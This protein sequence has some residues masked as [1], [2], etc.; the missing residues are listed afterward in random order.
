MTYVEA[1]TYIASL[2]PRGWRLGLD[3][4]AEFV[5][6]AGLVSAVD[7]SERKFIHV[8]GTNGKGSTTAYLQSILVASG[9][10]TGAFFSPYVLDPGERIQVGRSMLEETLFASLTVELKEIAESMEGTEFAGVTEFE[11]KTALGFLAWRRND[12]EWVALETGLGGR[13]DATNVVTPA[14]TVIV[15]I[16]LDHQSVLGNSIEEIA[17]E[18]AGIIKEGK[19]LILGSVPPEAA[20]VIL[21]VARKHNS[22]VWRFGEEIVWDEQRRSVRILDHQFDDLQPGVAGVWQGHNLALAIAALVAAEAPVTDLD[23]R[24]GA[25]AAHAPGRFQ[26]VMA[27]DRAFILD[28]AHNADSALALSKTLANSYGPDARFTFITNILQGHDIAS[29]Y[30]PLRH[31]I[32]EAVVA[33]IDFHRARPT[34]ET[35]AA[36]EGMEIPARTVATLEEAIEGTTSNEPIVITGSFYLVGEAGNLLGVTYK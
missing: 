9:V 31:Q 1:L 22:T 3:R 30:G 35:L 21:D 32:R 28:G 19:P 6:R 16:G 36:L 12:C 29:F 14:A 26:T 13:L 15:S 4:M 20:E 17:G 27:G 7:G 33:P 5:R 23:A 2:Q 24:K 18:K 34:L 8:A 25:N 10:R 11:F